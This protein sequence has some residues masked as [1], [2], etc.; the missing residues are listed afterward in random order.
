M[1]NNVTMKD[2]SNTDRVFKTTDNSNV[3]TQHTNVDTLPSLPA[4][5]NNIGDVDIASMPAIPA[6]VNNI[7]HVGGTD[8]E[9]VAASSTNQI[10]GATGALG[11]FLSHITVVPT[12]VNPGVVQIKDG[13]NAA[14]TVFAGGTGSITTLHPF[15]IMIGAKTTNGTWQITTGANLSCIVFGDFT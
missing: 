12:S 15:T 2:A 6:G 7:G 5:T 13:G 4:G 14:I 8:Y 11:D 10:M 3:H 1:A 9:A